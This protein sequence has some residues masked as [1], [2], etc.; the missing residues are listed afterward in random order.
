MGTATLLL[1]FDVLNVSEIKLKSNLQNESLGL[2]NVPV[3]V[4]AEG[5]ELVH[6]VDVHLLPR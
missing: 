3:Q 1:R 2:N 4:D 6:E 5:I